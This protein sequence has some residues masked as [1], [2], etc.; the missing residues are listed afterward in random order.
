[1]Q[2]LASGQ[3]MTSDNPNGRG[4]RAIV[5]EAELVVYM[6]RGG[7]SSDELNDRQSHREASTLPTPFFKR[8]GEAQSTGD[9][10]TGSTVDDEDILGEDAINECIDFVSGYLLRQIATSGRDPS[11]SQHSLLDGS[12]PK[13]GNNRY[14]MRKRRKVDY[15]GSG[16]DHRSLSSDA[17]E[18]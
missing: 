8:P 17:E 7:L 2:N 1:M 5:H 3:F 13:A 15:A 12:L 14:Q 18:G 16:S 9:G 6:K 11:P 4:E 10:D